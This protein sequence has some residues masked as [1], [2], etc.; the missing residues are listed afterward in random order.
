MKK[1]MNKSNLY[2]VNLILYS[3]EAII[4]KDYW[5]YSDYGFCRDS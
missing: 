5:M 2:M 3:L 1:W 4:G